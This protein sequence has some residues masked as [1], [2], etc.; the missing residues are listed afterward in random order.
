M[1]M[2]DM[3]GQFLNEFELTR[4]LHVLYDKDEAYVSC[5]ASTSR[6]ILIMFSC[7][8]AVVRLSSL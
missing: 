3:K 5:Y 8:A 1:D 6:V 4:N 2:T 7:S